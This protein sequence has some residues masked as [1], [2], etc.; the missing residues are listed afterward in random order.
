M[1]N[2]VFPP[3]AA[4]L[5]EAI[6]LRILDEIAEGQPTRHDFVQAVQA[7][8]DLTDRSL[9]RPSV[10]DVPN[11][12]ERALLVWRGAILRLALDELRRLDPN[13][14]AEELIP[15]I[16]KSLGRR[17]SDFWLGPD[18]RIVRPVDQDP[19]NG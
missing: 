1:P 12:I 2:P 11:P 19:K 6:C 3:F 16:G 13:A 5:I 18:G 15:R 14:P 17:A 9:Q 8:I 10:T 7:Q 4:S